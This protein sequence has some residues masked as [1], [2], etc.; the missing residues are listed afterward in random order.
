MGS[1]RCMLSPPS[2]S[3]PLNL[4]RH[5]RLNKLVSWLAVAAASRRHLGELPSWELPGT[6]QPARQ[7]CRLRAILQGGVS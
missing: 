1:S 7:G 2:P 3:P 4:G 6:A 5:R